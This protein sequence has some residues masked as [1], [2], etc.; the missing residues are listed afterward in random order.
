MT[1]EFVREG[2]SG[3]NYDS[4]LPSSVPMLRFLYELCWVLVY[5]HT[6]TNLPSSYS[7]NLCVYV[8]GLLKVRRKW[9]ISG[10]WRVADS[11]L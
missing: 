2:K 1:E 5:I 6:L 4:K 8:F 9:V 7:P 3:G 11:E 10:P